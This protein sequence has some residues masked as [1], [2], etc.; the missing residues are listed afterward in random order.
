VEFIFSLAA[1]IAVGSC[2]IDWK[3]PKFV[4]EYPCTVNG[5]SWV[6]YWLVIEM[7][8]IFLRLFTLLFVYKCKPA[9]EVY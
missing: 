2:W 6:G 4:M 5:Q 9:K 7:S 1:L 8:A 3:I